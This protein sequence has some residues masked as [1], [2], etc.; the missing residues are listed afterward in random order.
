MRK[1]KIKMKKINLLILFCSFGLP[2]ALA[3]TSSATAPLAPL[4][5][6]TLFKGSLQVIG[7]HARALTTAGPIYAGDELK[8]SAQQT[9]KI[10]FADQSEVWVTPNS[11]FTIQN[12]SSTPH[13]RFGLFH[14]ESGLVRASVSKDQG[15]FPNFQIQTASASIGV[16]GTDFVAETGGSV[17]GTNVYTLDGTVAFAP[18]LA[19]LKDEKSRRLISAGKQ[20][21]MHPGVALPSVSHH[22]DVNAL[23]ERLQKL[24]P[25]LGESVKETNRERERARTAKLLDGKTE[26][27]ARKLK[28]KEN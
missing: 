24:S 25:E 22:L 23:A 28:R 9:V 27:P 26:K 13:H 17:V 14:L 5:Q 2:N 4:G 15:S 6:A 10:T 7:P 3:E 16:R 20:S 11:D 21:E 12:Y 8:T 1:P 19:D 18:T